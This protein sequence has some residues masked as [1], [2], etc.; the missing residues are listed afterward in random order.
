MRAR[1]MRAVSQAGGKPPPGPPAVGSSPPGPPS[2]TT[3]SSPDSTP[4]EARRAVW[5]SVPTRIHRLRP[6][7]TGT[8]ISSR[9][10]PLR[11]TQSN[12]GRL[13][14]LPPEKTASVVAPAPATEIRH[15]ALVPG[16]SRRQTLPTLGH[17][18]TAGSSPVIVALASGTAIDR[19]ARAVGGRG[20]ATSP[21]TGAK[22]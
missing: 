13:A 12:G 22:T 14:G 16:T 9:P 17:G 8:S 7:R 5:L 19:R 10:P 18:G 15:G 4:S 2:T 11:L 6:R 21:G 20:P 1:S 3:G